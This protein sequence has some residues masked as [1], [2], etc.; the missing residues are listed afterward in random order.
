MKQ[1]KESRDRFLTELQ[2]QYSREMIDFSIN[3]AGKLDIHMQKYK[4]LSLRWNVQKLTQNRSLKG[5]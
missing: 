3:G 4:L 2:R 1:N 5:M